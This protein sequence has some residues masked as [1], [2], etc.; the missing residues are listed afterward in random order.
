MGIYVAIK[1][2]D[3]PKSRGDLLE[4]TSKRLLEA[5]D[6]EV[7]TEVRKTGMELD[8]LCQNKTN[9]AKKLFVECKAYNDDDKIQADVITNLSGRLHIK[10]YKEAWLIATS[11]LGK[12]AKGLVDD[13]KNGE[14]SDKFTFYA[15]RQ[16]ITALQSAHIIC[17]ET[18]ATQKIKDLVKDSSSLGDT[19]LLI[20]CFGDFWLT[21]YL[22]GGEINGILFSHASN[23]EIVVDEVLIDNLQQLN[24]KMKNYDFGVIFKLLDPNDKTIEGRKLRGAK[25]KEEY[26][27]RMAA[28]S[29]VIATTNGGGI[30]S[31]DDLFV[32]PDIEVIDT[33]KTKES[34]DEESSEKILASS[35]SAWLIFGDDLSGKTTLSYMLQRKFTESLEVAVRISPINLKSLKQ[36]ALD[37]AVSKAFIDQY[38]VG[39]IPVLT[40]ESYLQDIRKNIV[41]IV[42]D[43]DKIKAKNASDL[44][45]LA[46]Y[47]HSAYSKVIIFSSSSRELEFMTSNKSRPAFEKYKAYRLLQLGH[48]KR[49]ELI[50]KWI[51]FH[52]KGRLNEA[53]LLIR[54]DEFASRI[55]IAIGTNYLPTYSFYVLTILE[56]LESGSK[57]Q[58]QGS[59]YASLYGHLVNHALIING[60]RPLDLGFYN[61]YLAYLARELYRRGVASI[62]TTE[63]ES[64]FLDYLSLMK[65]DKSYA[66][67]HQKLV[68]SRILRID[69]DQYIFNLPYYRYFFLA[70]YLSDDIE[71]QETKA[72]IQE[73]VD[74]LYEDDSA[75]TVVF[76]VHHSKNSEIIDVIVNKAKSQFEAI[77][78]QTLI[79]SEIES[80]NTLITE[81]MGFA[82]QSGS[83]M[84]HRKKRLKQQDAYERKQRNAKE[85]HKDSIL[86]VYGQI[87]SAFRTIDVLGKITSNYSGELTGSRKNLIMKELYTLGFRSLRTF[88]ESFGS[89][90]DSLR[91]HIETK[92][93][94]KNIT[95]S[96]DKRKAANQIIYGFTHIIIYSFIKRVSDGVA[97]PDLIM[98]L[99]S[100]LDDTNGTPAA[101]LTFISTRL[102]FP[103]GLEKSK[104]DIIKFYNESA[105]NSLVRDLVRFLVL[106]H[107][108]KFEVGY[109]EIQSICN[110]LNISYAK[111]QQKKM[112]TKNI[113]ASR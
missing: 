50:E 62:G 11:E 33:N 80:I 100:V 36:T 106:E 75:N 53:T 10:K 25:L 15:P 17:T 22:R 12:E 5:H 70:K 13:I 85:P 105:S 76:L 48:V 87:T 6:Y 28:T 91:N 83:A 89:Y 58:L 108:Y 35:D 68:D 27:G 64:F 57:A 90:T 81:D 77:T 31:L 93:D 19:H 109:Q 63:L 7:E 96:V 39:G 16:L 44:A 23:G 20:S 110:Q 74:N 54:K 38:D 78:P 26:N 51:T 1:D 2:G 113:S 103:G 4:R 69:D 30:A 18:V 52:D 84:E 86:D 55:N 56:M 67:I 45:S 40:V 29:G 43:F 59:E 107:L 46:L 66:Q 111:V 97:S 47:M 94:D 101:R 82:L 42:D 71:S 98:T 49:D 9:P 14:D 60:V 73:L 88:L 104:A 32:Y 99:E 24:F 112:K 21:E 95:S 34:S 3:S 41:L 61:T 72:T 79:A 37:K 65:L 8:L 92:I 102:S